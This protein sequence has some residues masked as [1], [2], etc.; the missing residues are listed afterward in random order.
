V[1]SFAID[2]SN[3]SHVLVSLMGY[4]PDNLW[5]TLDNGVTWHTIDGAGTS[6]LPEVPV[7]WVVMHPTMHDLLFVATDIGVFH[8]TDAG[9]SWAPLA[10]GPE[11]VCIDQLVWKNDRQLLCVSHGRGVW[12]ATLPLAG[13]Q[14]VGTGCAS[15]T[16]PVLAATA[17]VIGG[18]TTF[19]MAAA[20]PNSLVFFAINF[21]APVNVPLGGCIVHVDLPNAYAYATSLTSG[22]GAWSHLLALP[23][24]PSLVGV[25]L[26]AQNLVIGAGGPMFG[27][28]DLSTGLHLFLGL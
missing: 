19:S 6:A 23:A 26:T 13:T 4:T 14:T 16:P 17:P 2:P 12:L 18:S 8:S 11:N 27:I 25:E 9:A 24:I 15:G 7:S 10:G 21:G 28:G 20:R 5:E 1:S 3:H 22:T